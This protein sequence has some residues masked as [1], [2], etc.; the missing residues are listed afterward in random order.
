MSEGKYLKRSS[1]VEPTPSQQMTGSFSS[2]DQLNP[3]SS[4]RSHRRRH[5]DENSVLTFLEPDEASAVPR[6]LPLP[7][8]EIRGSTPD[9][10]AGGYNTSRDTFAQIQP[11]RT[12]TKAFTVHGLSSASLRERWAKRQEEVAR[13]AEVLRANFPTDTSH[14]QNGLLGPITAHERE[15]KHEDDLGV[16]LTE[17]ER[18]RRMVEERQRKF[19]E[20]Q[21][22]QLEMVQNGPMRNLAPVDPAMTSI[23][24]SGMFPAPPSPSH[25]AR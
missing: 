11:S 4:F 6:P 8:H 5:Y 22:K 2:L 24:E 25:A 14:P 20:L 16:V 17:R 3:G 15:R 13:E 23:P 7:P 18:E 12:V 21:R 10:E 1:G 9:M 19:D